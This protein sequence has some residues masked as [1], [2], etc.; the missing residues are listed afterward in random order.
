MLMK[1][2]IKSLLWCTA[3]WVIAPAYADLPKTVSLT[4]ESTLWLVGDS[5]LHGFTCRTTTMT[6]T[7]DV[8]PKKTGLLQPGALRLMQLAIPVQHLHSKEAALDKNMLKALKAEEYPEIVFQLSK[9]EVSPSTKG[10]GASQIRA[11][12]VLTISGKTQP[13][14]LVIEASP[15]DDSLR[16]HGEYSLLMTDYGIKPPKMMMGTI[17]VK[18]E[19]VIHFDLRLR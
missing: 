19:I 6:L 8:D 5:T 4:P 14:V 13:I 15:K 1:R 3:L 10:A 11:E 7:S 2:K 17:K 9:Y 12:G 16:L 18:N